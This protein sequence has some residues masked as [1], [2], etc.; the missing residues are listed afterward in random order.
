MAG[1]DAPVELVSAAVSALLTVADSV[2]RLVAARDAQ[3]P[4]GVQPEKPKSK[5]K[6]TKRKG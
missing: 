5:T 6:A 1:E 4:D 3:V 2:D